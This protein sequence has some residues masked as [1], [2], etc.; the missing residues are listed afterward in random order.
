MTHYLCL[1]GLLMLL[2]KLYAKK[3]W[4]IWIA[5]VFLSLSPCYSSQTH[6]SPAESVCANQETGTVKHS[7]SKNKFDF[8]PCDKLLQG[9]ET[10]TKK[11]ML[12]SLL[13]L[14]PGEQTQNY[15]LWRWKSLAETDALH[16]KVPFLRKSCKYTTNLFKPHNIPTNVSF[17]LPYE[18]PIAK[19]FKCR[20]TL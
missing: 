5:I 12:L 13:L 16:M 10:S 4:L 7:N 3:A 1:R 15:T 14:F 2:K 8:P 18:E 19:Q 11:I 20:R 9:L 17:R 6:S